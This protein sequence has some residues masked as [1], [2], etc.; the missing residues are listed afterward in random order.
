M[1]AG[2]AR[3]RRAAGAEPNDSRAGPLTMPPTHTRPNQTSLMVGAT[4][5]CE[6]QAGAGEEAFEEGGPVLHPFEPG[7][8]QGGELGEVALGQVGE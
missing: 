6:V 3:C 4:E 8:D 7:L 5:G 2:A 1:A